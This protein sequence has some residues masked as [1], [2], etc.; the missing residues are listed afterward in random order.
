MRNKLFAAALLFFT[1]LTSSL[2]SFAQYCRVEGRNTHWSYTNTGNYYY[3]DV[4]VALYTDSTCTTPYVA[5]SNVNVTVDFTY[6]WSEGS[7]SQTDVWQDNVTIPAG[8]SSAVFAGGIIHEYHYYYSED[9][10]DYREDI[11]ERYWDVSYVSNNITPGT[12][13]Y[14][15]RY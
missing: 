8:S 7:Y 5:T 15:Y 4:Y 9:D 12:S 1:I 2:S 6:D 10:Q 13:V 14:Q 3:G 11:Y